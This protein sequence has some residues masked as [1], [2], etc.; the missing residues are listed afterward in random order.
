MER[1]CGSSGSIFGDPSGGVPSPSILLKSFIEALIVG[2]HLLVTVGGADVEVVK[3]AFNGQLGDLWRFTVAMHTLSDKQ[4]LVVV[5]GLEGGL[6]D[7]HMQE[8]L[9]RSNRVELRGLVEK[10]NTVAKSRG[11]DEDKV[12]IQSFESLT[13][14]APLPPHLS[15]SFAALQQFNRLLHRSL[16]YLHMDLVGHQW[17][18]AHLL[19]TT[20]SYLFTP[21]KIAIW[22]H[23]LKIT[24]RTGTS[25][26]YETLALNRQT[27]VPLFLQ[28]FH[29]LHAMDPQKL[30]RSDRAYFTKLEGEQGI[31]DGG[32]YRQS[33]NDY[34]S[35]LQS[36]VLPY[37]EEP[38]ESGE[39]WWWLWWW[40][41]W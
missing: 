39:W 40:W 27:G 10:V 17:S 22:K 5:P 32:L 33:F 2:S 18:L 3:Q 29:K 24:D 9:G 15:I 41:W 23:A 12:V 31:D 13:G 14:E 26:I 34:C 16:P 38:W 21:V 35:E 20:K 11:Y 19:A 1:A 28:A 36:A 4:Q 37:L 25:G 7:G 8:A 30:R 6:M